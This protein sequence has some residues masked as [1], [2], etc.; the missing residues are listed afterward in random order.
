MKPELY[1][2]AEYEAAWN[3][4]HETDIHDLI[5]TLRAAYPNLKIYCLPYGRG[6]VELKKLWEAGE[7][8]EIPYHTDFK[9]GVFRD[10]TGHAGK[11]LEA[12]GGL[13]WLDGIYGVDLS[14]YDYETGYNADLKAMGTVLMAKPGH[15]DYDFE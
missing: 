14:T 10:L 13:M 1:T 3:D 2:A 6:A 5:D 8:P 15:Q 12:L 7:L 9:E 11:M 4:F